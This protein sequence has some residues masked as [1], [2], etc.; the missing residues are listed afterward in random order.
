MSVARKAMKRAFQSIGLH[1]QRYPGADNIRGHL[2][3]LFRRRSVDCVIDVGAN[4]GQY[5]GVLRDFGYN[6][7]IVSFEP[8]LEA[9]LQ[10]ELGAADDSKWDVHKAAV[11][12]A[13]GKLEINVATSS[14]VSS[15]LTPTD[16]YLAAHYGAKVRRRELVE[17]V[18]IADVFDSIVG[19]AKSI[20]LKT[21][22]QGFDLEVLRGAEPVLDQIVG[23]QIEI[24]VQPIY[25]GMPTYLEALGAISE[26]GF[27]PSSF[28]PVTR[29]KGLRAIEFDGVFLR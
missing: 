19:D 7:R 12:S 8:V 18:S 1:V 13:A 26:Y 20:Y 25:N 16:E 6:G 17:V 23:L 4:R 27:T 3:E 15:F 2:K 24:S 9:F 14:S 22:T 5:A 11:G 29:D 28:F 10:L 21:D